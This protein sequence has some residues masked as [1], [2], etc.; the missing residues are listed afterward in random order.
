[1]AEQTA[2]AATRRPV[3][4]EQGTWVFLFGDMVVFAVFF[5]TFLVERGKAPGQFEFARTTMHTSIRFTNTL[6]L[7]TSS[8]LVVVAIG[9]IRA[10]ERATAARAVLAT[11]CCGL[12]FV[13]LKVSEYVALLAAGHGTGL[14][15]LHVCLGLAALG[16]LLAQT[17]RTALSPLRIAVVEG[18]AC[19]W[20]LVDLLCGSCCSRCS[21]W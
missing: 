8:L 13:G 14:H 1:M 4:G 15:L 19:L 17:R 12:V 10:D 20:H 6:V 2:L 21:I 5:T 3:P 9:A 18:A 16:F 7:L 11:M